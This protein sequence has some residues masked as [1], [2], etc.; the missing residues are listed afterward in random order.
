MKRCRR[1]G[2]R[3]LVATF[4]RGERGEWRWFDDGRLRGS[5]REGEGF[6]GH[7][8]NSLCCCCCCILVRWVRPTRGKRRKEWG[9]V[10]FDKES[11]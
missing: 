5:D 3:G 6:S 11:P 8:D 1:R 2:P 9:G 4:R 7:V 10:I